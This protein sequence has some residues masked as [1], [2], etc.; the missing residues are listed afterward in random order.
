MSS[1][2]KIVAFASPLLWL[3]PLNPTAKNVGDAQIL[4]FGVFGYRNF[5]LIASWCSDRDETQ[6]TSGNHLVNRYHAMYPSSILRNEQFQFDINNNPY[7]AKKV[8]PP[9]FS[10]LSTKYQFKLE[11]KYR[12]RAKLAWARPRWTKFTKLTQW[13]ISICRLMFLASTNLYWV[14]SSSGRLSSSLLWFRSKGFWI[15][16]IPR[17][18]QSVCTFGSIIS[19]QLLGSKMVQRPRRFA[20]DSHNPFARSR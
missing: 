18:E 11:R 7:R 14:Q 15:A 12:R 20:V 13:G 17:G 16:S 8:W 5:C 19:K 10:K 1:K 6:Q 2:I 4:A 9:D 3:L